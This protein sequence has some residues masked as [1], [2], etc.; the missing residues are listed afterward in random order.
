MYK[1]PIVQHNHDALC[2]ILGRLL[3]NGGS[4]DSSFILV[5]HSNDRRQ[6]WLCKQRWC[7]VDE[8]VTK[9]QPFVLGKTCMII[10]RLYVRFGSNYGLL[11]DSFDVFMKI[12][13]VDHSK[14][15]SQ[16]WNSQWPTVYTKQ[17]CCN[18]YYH[19]NSRIYM[20]LCA[21][22][23]RPRSFEA[24]VRSRNGKQSINDGVFFF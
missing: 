3:I 12:T 21:S 15:E 10:V 16:C 1:S 9:Q 19:R 20:L 4:I 24:P 13:L 14:V 23:A 18:P 2:A 7:S 17:A 8:T 6:C 11:K 22:R 5:Y